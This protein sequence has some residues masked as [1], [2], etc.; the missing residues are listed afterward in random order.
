MAGGDEQHQ[1][2]D[3]EALSPAAAQYDEGPIEDDMH[4]VP[5]GDGV[6]HQHDA[7]P[8]ED[9]HH[10]VAGEDE[11][12]GEGEASL[13]A[14]SEREGGKTDRRKHRLT[15]SKRTDTARKQFL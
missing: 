3:D 11:T 13:R 14:T 1:G 2:G 6:Q 5:R 10:R 7:G 12:A 4:R 8:L 9:D 15:A